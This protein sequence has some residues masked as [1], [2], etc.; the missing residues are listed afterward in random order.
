MKKVTL[1]IAMAAL[2]MFAGC[3]KD[4][5]TQGTTL[6]AS[7]TQNQGDSKTSLYPI[8]DTEAEI[9]WTTGDK[10]LVSNGSTPVQFTLT[11]G[12]GFTNGTFTYNGD[13]TFG[14]MNVAVYPETATINGTTVSLTLPETQTFTATGTFG[15]GMNPMLGT[16]TNTEDLTFT[17]LCGVLGISLKVADGDDD[18][19]ITAI[20]IESKKDEKLN[21]KFEVDYT[22]S[23]CLEAASDNTG[24]NKVRLN[25]ATTLTS[26]AKRFYFVVPDGT[27]S[28]GFYLKVYIDG[29][30][31]PFITD[32]DND[33]SVYWNTVNMMPDMTV[34]LAYVDLGLPS[35]L[36]WATRNVGANAPE[37]FGDYFAWGE[38]TP[39]YGYTWENYQYYDGSNLTKYTGSDGLVTLLPEDDA[40]TVNWGGNWRMPTK[41]EFEELYNN[42][43]VTW[44]EQNGVNGLL[45]TASNGKSLFLPAAG[46]FN[47]YVI[48]INDGEYWSRSLS[49]DNP[50]NAWGVCFNS[51]GLNQNGYADRFNGRT[52]RPVRATAKK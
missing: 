5:E 43:T 26:D 34:T 52:I 39:K 36:L 25:C 49:T 2:V 48:S 35:G 42:T 16:F 30:E 47:Y 32:T 24:T 23:P 14:E 44:T 31:E 15:N 8:S 37:K 4:K 19:D 40:A 10:I 9:R 38:T 1:L 41:E 22:G 27:L 50:S 6:K 13:Y 20:E 21:G 7:I 45:F 18:I 17:S 51:F 11:N 12:N 46:E 29:E 33:I 28:R 3:N